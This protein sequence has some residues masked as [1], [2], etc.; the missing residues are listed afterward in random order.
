M[1][2]KGQRKELSSAQ[3]SK[4]NALRANFDRVADQKIDKKVKKG[5][6]DTNSIR[7]QKA[8]R[9]VMYTVFRRLYDLGYQIQ[10]L[11]N[12]QIRHVEK[13]VQDW[14][15]NGVKPKTMTNYLSVIR[16]CAGWVGKTKLMPENN[17]VAFFLPDVDKTLLKVTTLALKSKSWSE[18]G[19]D[20][21]GKIREADALCIIF[22]AMLRLALAFGFRR[23]EQIKCVPT[24]ID[25]G[26][27][28]TLR[29]GI[30]KSG[31]DR[32]IEIVDDFQRYCLDHAKKIAGR[33]GRLGW[34]GKTY[35]Q[36]VNNYNYRMGQKLGITGA[37]ADCVGH[38]LRAEFAENMALRL[39]FVPPT[40]GGSPTQM[41][42]DAI[43]GI[44]TK[45][46]EEMGHSREIITGAYYG[47]VRLKPQVPGR[48]VC[49]MVIGDGMIASLHMN[50]TP[51]RAETGQFLPLTSVERNRT[52]V[53]IQI[54]LDGSSQPEG[55]W[56][57]SGF[58]DALLEVVRAIDP[59]QRQVLS[60][61]LQLV[62]GRMGWLA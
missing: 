33:G 1:N 60:K 45:V 59:A 4:L 19:I 57:I 31:R 55:M 48:K 25:G 51:L 14:H 61:K 30:T 24:R 20:V 8:T 34:P 10:D 18:Q 13:L 7:T 9:E 42:R 44:Q 41:P 49:S 23:K 36:S 6:G 58:S 12:L 35:Q 54:E 21:V 47:S 46:T 52:A 40:L 43:K 2:E 38:G 29:G 16:K 3:L 50:P 22:G 26:N 53:H 56:R 5:K 62:M 28:V 11:K 15:S 17:A 32:D 27:K 39:G 37:N